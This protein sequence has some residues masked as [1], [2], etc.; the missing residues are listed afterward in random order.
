[1]R[2]T[3][4]KFESRFNKDQLITAVKHASKQTWVLEQIKKDLKPFQQGLSY[5]AV[6][7]WF[8]R[9]QHESSNGEVVVQ[10]R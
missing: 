4:S 8:R 5:A 6:D 9:L 7:Q 2:I 3:K 10:M 1:M